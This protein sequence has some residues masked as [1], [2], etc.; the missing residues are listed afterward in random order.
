MCNKTAAQ[1]KY[2]MIGIA[3]VLIVLI[4]VITV[5]IKHANNKYCA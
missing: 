5:L 3:I 2:E 4:D 1:K